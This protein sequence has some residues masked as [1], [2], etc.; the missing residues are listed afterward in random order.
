MGYL[1]RL[2]KLVVMRKWLEDTKWTEIMGRIAQVDKLPP[3]KPPDP[4]GKFVRPGGTATAKSLSARP[5]P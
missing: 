3:R 1:I 2:R 4:F 5:I